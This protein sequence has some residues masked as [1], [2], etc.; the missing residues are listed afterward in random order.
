MFG[1]QSIFIWE[2]D[3]KR[4]D[5]EQYVLA[6]LKKRKMHLRLIINNVSRAIPGYNTI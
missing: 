1:W 2:T 6:I 5:A 4:V 3:I